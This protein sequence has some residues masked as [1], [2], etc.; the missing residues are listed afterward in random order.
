VIRFKL[1]K[2]VLYRIISGVSRVNRLGGRVILLRTF[3]E[4]Y[5]DTKMEA[6]VMAL[7]QK[8]GKPDISL[9]KF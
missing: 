4:G 3:Q 2:I 8:Y 6:D 7:V 1:N 9:I 5:S